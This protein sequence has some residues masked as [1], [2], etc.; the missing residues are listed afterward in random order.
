MIVIDSSVIVAILKQ[1]P[2]AL[3]LSRAMAA[4]RS[5]VM[6]A[7]TYVELGTVLAGRRADNRDRVVDDL[8]ILLGDAAV[9]VESVTADLARLALRARIRYGKGFGSKKGLN[10]G[11]SFA[12]ALAKSHGAP[13]LFVGDDFNRT[14]IKSALA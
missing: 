3:A 2:E 14:D 4:A 13:L 7:V 6:S 10:F 5:R 9:E 12:Y 11:D 8:D 1:E